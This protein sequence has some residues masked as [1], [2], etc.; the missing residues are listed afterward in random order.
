MR[1]RSGAVLPSRAPVSSQGSQWAAAK[2]RL[3][4]LPDRRHS[5]GSTARAASPKGGLRAPAG[6]YQAYL[7]VTPSRRLRRAKEGSHVDV[8]RTPPGAG[9]LSKP[10][11][12]P[13]RRVVSA[14]RRC[15]QS[16][17]CRGAALTATVYKL[18]ATGGPVH[19]GTSGRIRTQGNRDCPGRLTGPF[20]VYLVRSRSGAVLEGAGFKPGI[21][22][23]ESEAKGAA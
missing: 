14:G 17:S 20:G 5:I 13:R 18:V 6:W 10:S 16:G 3:R 11:L 4:V 23:S 22:A 19:F 2:A 8:E 9:A 15:A 1:S 12:R 7:H 21:W